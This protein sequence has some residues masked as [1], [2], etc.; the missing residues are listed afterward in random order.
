[1]A[2]DFTGFL[3]GREMA[4]REGVPTS[5]ANQLGLM[6]AVMND[7]MGQMPAMMFTMMMARREAEDQ[8]PAAA[9]PT[10]PPIDSTS[11]AGVVGLDVFRR[12]EAPDASA[13]ALLAAVAAVQEAARNLA[14]AKEAAN[15]GR[16]EGTELQEVVEAAL[17]TLEE[18]KKALLDLLERATA[19]VKELG[20]DD[21]KPEE[22][23]K[24]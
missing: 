8:A 22:G 5:R 11:P 16:K 24:K 19:A 2:I 17:K 23:K 1:M 15:Q 18:K 7:S 12:Q 13:S 3:L 4:R 10:S 9:P 6:Q 14:E 21:D 20:K